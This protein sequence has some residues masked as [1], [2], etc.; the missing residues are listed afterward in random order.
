MKFGF[1]KVATCTP[2]LQVANCEFNA[3]QIVSY[4]EQAKQAGIKILVFPELSVT[5]ATCDDLFCQPVL[6]RSACAALKSVVEAT[7]NSDVLTFVGCPIQNGDKLYNC[8]VVIQNGNILGAVPKT[9]LADYNENYESRRFTP[10]CK[11]VQSVQIGGKTVPFGTELLFSDRSMPECTVAVEVGSEAFVTL[12]PS[13]SHAQNGA[14]IIVNLAAS[15]ELVGRASKLADAI[16]DQSRRLTCAYLYAGA[17]KGEST[18]DLV[19]SGHSVIAENGK[20]LK[21][22]K[23]FENGLTVTELDAQYLSSE[24]QKTAFVAKNDG[25][26]V[27]DVAF[28]LEQTAL[29]RFVDPMP[30]VP[31]EAEMDERADLI[32]SLQAHALAKR[33]V[34]TKTGA[35]VIGVSGGLDSSLA[36]LVA[37]EALK[38]CGRPS[39]DVIAV[40]MPCFG[41][42]S[43]TKNNAYALSEALG[44]TLKEVNVK[45]SVTQHFADIGHD[46][47]TTDV[48]FENAQARERTQ[49]LMD[50]ANMTNGM[51]IGT[52]DLSEIALGWATYN[53]DHMS[54]YGVNG[55][56]PKTLVRHLIAY[57]VKT[58]NEKLGAVLADI[59]A[60]PVSPEL[61]PPQEGEISQITEDIVGPYELH[62]FFLYHLVRL[63]QSPA[64]IYRLALY[65]FDGRYGKETI[66][67]WL[68]TFLR[69]FFTQQFKRSCMADGVK[70]GS[71]ALSPRGDWKMPSDAVVAVWMNDLQQEM[72]K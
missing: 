59:L 14:K 20:L 37:V 49:V 25:Y 44:V 41:T 35:L 63:G 43:R 17:G 13:V 29:T 66:Q 56:V 67:K 71:V 5:G 47:V 27:I 31:S 16:K 60:T 45:A 51:V 3:A 23:L 4:V 57:Y 6:I 42:T 53:G 69:R 36:L 10:A 28:S 34:H 64:K 19:F 1:V 62:D 15:C 39:T 18:T 7:E 70:V 68:S 2:D 9:Y 12:P 48:T 55:S 33:I 38:L 40:T 46:G 32:L 21:Q 61:L 58:Q 52:G 30:F 54:M 50:I 22:S 8:A 24:R 65:A 11:G 72:A 26:R